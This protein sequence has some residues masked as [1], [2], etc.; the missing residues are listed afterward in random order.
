MVMRTVVIRYESRSFEIVLVKYKIDFTA[1]KAEYNT[2]DYDKTQTTH[3]E[4]K[5]STNQEVKFKAIYALLLGPL[6]RAKYN[7]P[8]IMDGEQCLA[9]NLSFCF[10][11]H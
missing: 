8:Y 2:Y 1:N 10:N 6:W 5:L 11:N 3:K 4:V 9:I 7:N